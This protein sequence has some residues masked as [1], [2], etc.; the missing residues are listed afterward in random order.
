M[1]PAVA[2]V[3]SSTK[4]S[5]CGPGQVICTFHPFSGTSLVYLQEEA[6]TRPDMSSLTK[7]P[8]PPPLSWRLRLTSIQK[9]KLSPGLCGLARWTLTSERGNKIGGPFGFSVNQGDLFTSNL[10]VIL[11]TLSHFLPLEGAHRGNHQNSPPL[12]LKSGDSTR[13]MDTFRRVL[14]GSYETVTRPEP[15]TLSMSF[16]T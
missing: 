15:R 13:G 6:Y 16:S 5:C 11:R 1:A 3:N 8:L 14:A 9:R 10:G 4:T 7:R 12:A 2:A